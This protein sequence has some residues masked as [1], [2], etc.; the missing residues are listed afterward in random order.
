MNRLIKKILQVEFIRYWAIF[1]WFQYEGMLYY[2]K[3]SKNLFVR[4]IGVLGLNAKR[5]RT[6][7]SKEISKAI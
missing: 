2:F 1:F 7:V 5:T 4:C 6:K 3:K